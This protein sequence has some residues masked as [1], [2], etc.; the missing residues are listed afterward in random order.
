MDALAPLTAG[1]SPT[2]SLTPGAMPLAIGVTALRK[3]YVA[4]WTNEPLSGV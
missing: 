1:V 2:R 4:C 3:D